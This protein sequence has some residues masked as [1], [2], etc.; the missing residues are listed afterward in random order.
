MS[1]LHGNTGEPDAS[2][3]MKQPG[4]TVIASNTLAV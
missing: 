1:S 3:L 2:A 4:G